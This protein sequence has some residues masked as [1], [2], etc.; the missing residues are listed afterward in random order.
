MARTPVAPEWPGPG[1]QTEGGGSPQPALPGVLDQDERAGPDR[2]RPYTVPP[3]ASLQAALRKAIHGDWWRLVTWQPDKQQWWVPSAS[4]PG[5]V[6]WLHTRP[7]TVRSDP[8]YWR[9]VCNCPAET[10]GKWLV[11][12][13][14]AAVWEWHCHR[15][16]LGAR[17]PVVPPPDV[18]SR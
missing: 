14:K 11:C 17:A 4:T 5:A 15:S 13:H 18:A 9:L 12:W 7:G 1:T 6:Y 10:S 3:D 2:E 16:P 8:W